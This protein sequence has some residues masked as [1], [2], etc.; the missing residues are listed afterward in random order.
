[1]RAADVPLQGEEE[2]RLLFQHSPDAIFVMDPHDPRVPWKILACND[3]ACRMNGYDREE[4]IGRPL[5]ILD[6][7]EAGWIDDATFLDRLRH[8]R[9]LHGATL[10]RRKDGSLFYIEFSTSLI[11]LGGRELALGVDRDLTERKRSEEALQ[12][13]RDELELRVE[14]RTVEL[15]QANERLRAEL[16]QREQAERRLA[17][18]YA[19]TRVL[20]EAPDFDAAGPRILHLFGEG[21][22]W[23]LGYLWL[24]DQPAGV[25]RCVATWHAPT[26]D[27]AEFAEASCGMTFAPGVGL[28]GQV[29]ETG[30]PLWHGDVQAASFPRLEMAARYDLR[31]FFAFPIRSGTE[32]FG[33]MEFFSIEIRPPDDALLN[34]VGAIG[35]HAG[36]FVERRRAEQAL[37]A[38][39]ARKTA[40]VETALDCVIT[41]DHKG[42]VVEWNRAAET[43]LGYRR[44]AA[45]GREMAELIIP[46][47]LRPRHRHGLKRYLETGEAR[48]IGQRIEVP[49]VRADGTEFP[50]EVTI[51]HIPGSEPPVFTG[52]VRD[53]TD[54]QRVEES[55]QLLAVASAALAATLDYSATLQEFARLMAPHFADWCAVDLIEDD[56]AFRRVALAHVD[57]AKVELGWE[58]ERCYGVDVMLPAG[59][60]MVLRTGRAEI[61]RDIGDDALRVVARD[62]QHLR[63]LREAGITAAMVVP[64]IARGR[65]LGAIS[66]AMAESGRRFAPT[67]V[68]LAEDLAHRAALAI[69]NARLYHE[70]E[71]AVHARDEFLSLAAHE[72]KTPLTSLLGFAEMLSQ[73]L[74]LDQPMTERDRRALGVVIAQA[75]RLSR[76]VDL[77]LDVARL[78]TGQ[79]ALDLEPLDLCALAREVAE[80]MQPALRRHTLELFCPETPMMVEGDELRLEQALQNLIGNAIKYSPDGGAVMLRVERQDGHAVIAVSDRGIGI[81]SESQE[82]LFERFYRARNTV[83]TQISGMG[84]GLFVVKEIVTHHGGT[85]EVRSVENEGSTFTIRLPLAQV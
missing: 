43:T 70:M 8:E 32:T 10:H 67:D 16:S 68:E 5:H 74:R 13:A 18:Q 77:L 69:D 72:L 35:I 31:G 2:F 44:E 73:R 11:T 40:I 22:A 3:V 83:G 34:M 64:M 26:T 81:P 41:M 58:V 28:I 65:T 82:R 29:W 79:L 62:E 56:G 60:A 53:I 47:S 17:V 12:R 27:D 30:R 46:P 20:A 39:E 1:M 6:P 7:G 9:T 25:L 19:I 33:V 85:V 63:V 84:M 66:F 52:F 23:E 61:Y 37:R 76:L 38:S 36:Q 24:V 21:L 45:L 57:P 59:V 55:A 14:Q 49:A 4:L 78:E 42:H 75:G 80:E 50:A 71:A 15:A 51:T 54:R 48:L